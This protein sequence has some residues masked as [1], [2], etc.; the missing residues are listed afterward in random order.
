VDGCWSPVHI[1]AQEGR[2]AALQCLVKEF[3]ADAN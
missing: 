1:A 2:L 3:G